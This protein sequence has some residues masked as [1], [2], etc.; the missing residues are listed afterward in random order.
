L[1]STAC[2][3]GDAAREHPEDFAVKG[4]AQD[5]VFVARVDVRVDVDLDQ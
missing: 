4:L 1:R 3:L 2:C 5:L